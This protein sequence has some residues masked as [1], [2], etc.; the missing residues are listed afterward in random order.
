MQ[1][2]PRPLRGRPPVMGQDERRRRILD[3][4]AT[5]FSEY[6]YAA[7]SIDE[8]AKTC[9]MSRKTIYGLFPSKGDLFAAL[10][11]QAVPEPEAQEPFVG[12][13]FEESL[14]HV[15]DRICAVSL[16][17]RGIASL[18]LVIAEAPLVPEL[19][20]IYY[21]NTV[22]RGRRYLVA[23]LKRLGAIFGRSVDDAEQLSDILFGA[24]V[25]GPLIHALVGDTRT[26]TASDTLSR[27][28]RIV[29][30]LARS[31]SGY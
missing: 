18:R 10:V 29:D 13:S 15:V 30:A 22:D 21:Q 8:V 2:T 3:A 27:T 9:G 23:E 4:A 26:H 11:M 17:P 20:S 5:V 19:A 24:V 6:G 28:R 7:A 25:A 14:N 1:V 16:A 31:S 12:A